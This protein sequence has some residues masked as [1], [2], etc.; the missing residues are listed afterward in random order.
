LLTLLIDYKISQFL[1]SSSQFKSGLINHAFAAALGPSSWFCNNNYNDNLIL[2][3]C[4]HATQT[5]LILE[6]P[7]GSDSDIMKSLP[8]DS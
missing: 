4:L 2:L 5:M 8:G 6:S 1:E 3:I 7:V